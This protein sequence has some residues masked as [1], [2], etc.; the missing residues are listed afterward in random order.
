MTIEYNVNHKTRVFLQPKGV[1][2]ITTEHPHTKIHSL[3]KDPYIEDQMYIVMQI[4]AE[5]GDMRIGM[6]RY[7]FTGI[8]L[9]DVDVDYLPRGLRELPDVRDFVARSR[10]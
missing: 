5:S 8:E 7:F 9:V 6:P 2:W 3:M 10:Y 1:G 4:M